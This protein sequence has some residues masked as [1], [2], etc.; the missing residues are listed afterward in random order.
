LNDIGI[1][2]IVILY[3]ENTRITKEFI[4]KN[5]PQLQLRAIYFPEA[6]PSQPLYWFPE[7]VEGASDLWKYA[8]PEVEKYFSQ[9]KVEKDKMKIKELYQRIHRLIYEDQPACF[10]YFP[11]NFFAISSDFT[12]TD[13]FFMN[14]L[15]ICNI[16]EWI[17]FNDT[18]ID[19][20]R[21]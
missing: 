8:N 2:L 10:L 14:P 19:K 3:D 1:K 9:A 17:K 7:V 20:K 16:K 13:S 11:Y 6:D 18:K 5:N 4:D 12:N 21:R 15:P